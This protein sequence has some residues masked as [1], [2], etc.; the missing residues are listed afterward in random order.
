MRGGCVMRGY[1]RDPERTAEVL[2]AEGWLTSSDLGRFDADGN[3]VLAGRADDMYIR[4]GFNVYPVEVENV[5]ADHPA[6]A[7]VAVV[8]VPAPVIG[9]IGVAVIVPAP[10]GPPPTLDELRAWVDGRL[11]DYKRPDQVV[12]VDELPLTS[13]L[14]VDKITQCNAWT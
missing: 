12:V 4:G 7:Q 1:W 8:G 6:V 5:L 3:L 14:K 13:M 2:D 9:E 11:A 10:G